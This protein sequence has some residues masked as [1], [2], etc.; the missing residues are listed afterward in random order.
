MSKRL[1]TFMFTN[2]TN[3]QVHGGNFYS[4][5]G[6]VNLG[7]RQQ[8]LSVHGPA[9]G[10]G[11]GSHRY[12]P[13]DAAS[14]FAVSAPANQHPAP[15]HSAT[16]MDGPRDS[17]VHI[18]TPHAVMYNTG[19]TGI[20][21]LH[22]HAALEALYNSAESFPQPQCHP[23]TRSQLLDRLWR[24]MLKP[25]NRVIW[26]HGPAGAGKSAIMHTLCQQLQDA[27]I[28]G[29]S[30]FF[31]RGH[32]SRGNAAALFTT[33]AYQL[34]LCD[35]VLK[36]PIL[37][38]I[39]RNPSLAGTSISSQLKELVVDPCLIASNPAPRILLVDGLDEC[40]GTVAQQEVLRSICRIFCHHALPVKIIIASRPEPDI[41]E[42]FEDPSFQGLQMTRMRRS[43]T[44]VKRFLRIEFSRIHQ[45]H[46]HTMAHIPTPW[47]SEDDLATLVE[48]SSGYFV[49][50]ATV[51]R[52]VD[53]KQ[54]R[55]S[56]Q[57]QIILN[58]N[59]NSGDSPFE[60]LD[61]LYIQI[62]SQVPTRSRALLLDILS[63]IST[64]WML[65]T[66]HIEQLLDLKTGD[67]RLT[68]RKLHSVLTVDDSSPVTTSHASFVEFLMIESRSTEFY[69][70]N[71]ERR[72][73]LGRSVLKILTCDERLPRED[74]VSWFVLAVLILNHVSTIFLGC[75]ALFG[76]RL[77][78]L[79]TH[80]QIC[81]PL[82]PN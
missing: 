11:L 42:I 1:Y 52:F 56:E 77:L 47:P 82:S 19:D 16:N 81:S 60:A 73:R 39:E 38:T 80:V 58:G 57:L 55:P 68:L 66:R 63:V 24:R 32:A 72:R 70:G 44:D 65:S 51:I 6:D 37:E 14:R 30:F 36:S 40:D 8:Q 18:T 15:P 5:S 48:T 49:Y 12:A 27:G 23:E 29:G 75:L 28:F 69:I 64:G 61:Q 78:R 53:D 76:S 10:N 71:A 22:R 33:L 2:S 59:S 9:R 54:F 21:I 45:E 3:F 41:R 46:R 74:H 4:V 26:L 25:Q 34:A 62:L 13:Y 35:P 43:F 31:K 7:I 50:A 79:W 67:V 20:H 17:T